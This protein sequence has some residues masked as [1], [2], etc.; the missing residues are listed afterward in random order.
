LTV[1]PHAFEKDVLP[2]SYQEFK[3]EFIEPVQSD[4][5]FIEGRQIEAWLDGKGVKEPWLLT[6]F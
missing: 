6:T 3:R 1:G 5:L 2:V 4:R